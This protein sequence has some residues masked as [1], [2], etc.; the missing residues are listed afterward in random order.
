MLYSATY[1]WWKIADLGLTSSGTTED[2]NTTQAGRG[3]VSYRAAELVREGKKTF[4]KKTDIW[5]L[6]CILHDLCVGKRAFGTDVAAWDYSLKKEPLQITFSPS[7]EGA[8]EIVFGSWIREMIDWDPARRPMPE[9][10][11]K[12]F[13]QL[14]FLAVPTS[15][16]SKT[17][18]TTWKD[19][20]LLLPENLISTD[21]P[22]NNQAM[23]T[24]IPPR[25][26]HVLFQG[27]HYSHNIK[28]LER[29]KQIAVA[30]E[31]LLGESHPQAI[32]SKVRL[33]W[34][35]FYIPQT[36]IA[37]SS[38]E[39]KKLLDLKSPN[40]LA[41]REAASYLAGIG[42]SEYSSDNY[43][44]SLLMFQKA[45]EIQSDRLLDSDSLSYTVAS[46]KVQL[47]KALITMKK[48]GRKRKR[49]T[50]DD[51]AS[52]KSLAVDAVSQLHLSY[53]CQRFNPKLGKEHIE[54]A[55]TMMSL[56]FGYRV[57]AIMKKLEL[58]PTKVLRQYYQSTEN[59]LNEALEVERK[60]LGDDHPHTLY[61][62]HEVAHV[63]LK[64]GR[65]AEGIQKLEEA[66][67]KQKYVLGIDDP[68]T[69]ATISSLRD[70][71]RLCGETKKLRDL[72]S[73]V[74]NMPTRVNERML[75]MCDLENGTDNEGDNLRVDQPSSQ[76]S[77]S[78]AS[79]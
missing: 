40:E 58:T 79:L 70:G 10:L 67:A 74:G 18:Q 45:L 22:S 19:T 65:T 32:H 9:A 2:H 36:S 28:T 48:P 1:G 63:D 41:D 13:W 66:L 72:L 60:S 12:R 61:T 47:T 17:L 50:S 20:D 44:E 16:T 56:A 38:E 51:V 52:T 42:W 62:L 64:E 34:T 15:P 4:N 27:S 8:A 57:L 33:A 68:D 43:D 14:L 53:S 46:A 78:Q 76:A 71:Y 5:S 73:Q 31:N 59:F 69:Q 24:Q 49:S 37:N 25:W 23:M 35:S 3:K 30:R 77:P 7:L 21:S 6:G 29:A 54:T 75:R 11:G 39:F 26:E 55:E